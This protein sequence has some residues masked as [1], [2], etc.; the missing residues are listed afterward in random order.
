MNPSNNVNY[1]LT[2]KIDELFDID[3]LPLQLKAILV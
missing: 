1:K 3:K 2:M